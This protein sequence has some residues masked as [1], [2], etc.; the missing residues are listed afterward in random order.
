M[1]EFEGDLLARARAFHRDEMNDHLTYRTLARGARDPR[2]RAVLERIAAME[3]GHARFWASVIEARGG[4]VPEPRVRRLRMAWLRLL[5]RVVS[6]VL[7]VSLLELGEAGA[8]QAYFRIWKEGRLDPGERDRLR[9]II[10]DELDHEIT[11]RKEAEALGL[12]NVRDF[13]L[14]MN[15]GLVEIL[16]AVTGLS[17]AYAGNPRVVAVSGLVVGVAGALSMGIGAFVSV[18]SQRQVNEGMRE[19]LDVLF[20]VA[21]ARAVKELAERLVAAGMPESVVR[22]VTARLGDNPEAL[23]R[24]LVTEEGEDELR[25]AL[26]TGFAY[27]FGVVFPVTPYFLA[28]DARGALLGSVTLAGLALAA[29]GSGIALVSGIRLR[30]KVL[31]M[32]VAGFSAAGLAYLFGRLMQAWFGIEV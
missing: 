28:E 14:G 23:R 26:F 12:S 3:R 31:E 10:E 9:A 16:G 22:D 11:F 29:V 20:A 2:M 13:I 4:R 7:L 5:Q 1:T 24:L 6:P 21:P 32:L 27:L 25:S 17:A 30:T 18:R 15:D 8:Q 19:H